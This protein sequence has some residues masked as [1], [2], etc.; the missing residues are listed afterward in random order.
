[1]NDYDYINLPFRQKVKR[2]EWLAYALD[3]TSNGVKCA[4][5]PDAPK[6]QHTYYKLGMELLVGY[7][8]LLML[9]CIEFFLVLC[10]GT[11]LVGAMG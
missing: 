1:M 11:V 2:I 4:P 3:C 10:V 9:D 7:K 6:W 5:G 8:A